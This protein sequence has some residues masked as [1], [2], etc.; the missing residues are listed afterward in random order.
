LTDLE[1]VE[2]LFQAASGAFGE[3]LGAVREHA[4]EVEPRLTKEH[5]ER[6]ASIIRLAEEAGSPEAIGDAVTVV[7]SE[8]RGYQEA[9]NRHLR[10]LE[11]QLSGTVNALRQVMESL[12]TGS[13]D[14][15]DRLK[16]EMERLKGLMRVDDL[17]ALRSGLGSSLNGLAGCIDHIQRQNQLVVAQLRDEIRTLHSRVETAERAAAIDPVTGVMNRHE[18]ETAIQREVESSSPFCLIFTWVK[19]LKLL[20]RQYGRKV[21]DDLTVAASRRFAD[22]V[23]SRG[24]V[25]RWSDDELI[26]IVRIQKGEAIRFCKD[27]PPQLKGPHECSHQGRTLHLLLQV[28]AGVVEARIGERAERLLD[29]ADTLMRA[30]AGN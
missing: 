1:Q 13:E 17:N 30:L 7:R 23:E 18:I 2:G 14:Q 4:V 11:E 25:G 12:A 9:A 28:S 5:R 27:L 15:Q 24:V 10:G 21:A 22:A 3:V 20:Q 8:L 29:R 6:L 19:N 26:A 16:T